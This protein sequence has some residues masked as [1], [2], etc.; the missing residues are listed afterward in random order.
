MTNGAH[1]KLSAHRLSIWTVQFSP[2]GKRLATAS[3]DG[4]V[5]IWDVANRKLER[6]LTYDTWLRPLD[7]S[8]DG[9]RLVVGVGD[10][11]IRVWDTTEWKELASLKGHNSF[12][13]HLEF[14]PDGQQIAS[15]GDDGTIRLWS[16][17]LVDTEEDAQE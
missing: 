14:S 7:F 10:G 9:T 4:T 15:A 8:P 1:V 5:K 12:T 3:S 2:D 16:L 17:Q 6:E 11:Q 13:F